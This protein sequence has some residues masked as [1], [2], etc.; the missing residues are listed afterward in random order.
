[1]DRAA[2]VGKEIRA[3][4]IRNQRRKGIGFPQGLICKIREMQGLIFK[5]KFSINPKPK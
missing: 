4:E 5:T 1:L 3:P 2:A